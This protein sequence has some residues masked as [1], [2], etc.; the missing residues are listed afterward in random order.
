MATITTPRRWNGLNADVWSKALTF[1]SNEDLLEVKPVSSALLHACESTQTWTGRFNGSLSRKVETRQDFCRLVRLLWTGRRSNSLL[2]THASLRARNAILSIQ[3][4]MDGLENITVERW[5]AYDWKNILIDLL[6]LNP[7]TCQR[8][9]TLTIEGSVLVPSHSIVDADAASVPDTFE[10][11]SDVTRKQDVA[12]RPN[13]RQKAYP[14]RRPPTDRAEPVFPNLQTL[15]FKAVDVG[16]IKCLVENAPNVVDLSFP[17]ISETKVFDYVW[18][19]VKKLTLAFGTLE[20]SDPLA[21]LL[22]QMPNVMKR[23]VN[24]TF[25]ESLV[26]NNIT[27]G[28]VLHISDHVVLPQI[29]EL[30]ISSDITLHDSTVTMVAFRNTT[31]P[32]VLF[33]AF[34]SVVRLRLTWKDYTQRK[35]GFKQDNLDL[36]VHGQWPALDALSTWLTE[37]WNYHAPMECVTVEFSAGSQEVDIAQLDSLVRCSR[38]HHVAVLVTKENMERWEMILPDLQ[39]YDGKRASAI[40]SWRDSIQKELPGKLSTD[41]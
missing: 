14:G 28:E 19:A 6:L 3:K 32:V 4:H 40:R 17:D 29:K 2:V 25:L 39:G 26:L 9:K 5:A 41:F 37:P 24:W 13:K 18:P 10:G 1:V 12:G 31:W 36:N 7:E 21:T 15:S 23:L 22:E 16:E 8:L 20:A 38:I 33:K 27:P 34:P 35:S 30:S 11:F